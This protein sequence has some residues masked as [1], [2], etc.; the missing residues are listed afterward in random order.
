MRCKSETLAQCGPFQ[1]HL[2]R[3]CGAISLHLHA[4]TLR[5]DTQAVRVLHKVIAQ[6]VENLDGAQEPTPLVPS[7]STII[8]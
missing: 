3:D 4:M 1:V 8:N 2:C 6:A 5:L 7:S